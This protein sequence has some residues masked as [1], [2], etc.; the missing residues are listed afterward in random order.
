[1]SG[2]ACTCLTG[3]GSIWFVD[4]EHEFDESEPPVPELLATAG[5]QRP[6]ASSRHGSP[7]E[8]P[9]ARSDPTGPTRTT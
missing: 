3:D 8:G 2:Q 5:K 7:S 6:R 4:P 9:S 1:M